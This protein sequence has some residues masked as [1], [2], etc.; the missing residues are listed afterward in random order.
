M[1][2]LEEIEAIRQLK[3]RYFRFLDMKRFRE[4]TAL[5]IADGST[6]YDNG[7]YSYKGHEEIFAFMDESMGM[8]EAYTSHQGHHPEITLLDD[9][10]ATGIWHFEDTVHRMDYQVAIYGAGIYWDEYVKVD[11][12]WKFRYTGYERLWVRQE[13]LPED[14]SRQIRGMFDKEERAISRGRGLRSGE[15][16]LFPK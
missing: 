6:A 9:T 15:D 13:A 8:P 11:G 14:P 3:Y 10:N 1:N 5:F 2:K 16:A 7:R 4:L 12:E